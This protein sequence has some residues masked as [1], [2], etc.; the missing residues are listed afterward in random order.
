[1]ILALYVMFNGLDYNRKSWLYKIKTRSSQLI[2]VLIFLLKYS[3]T[4]SICTWFL[5]NQFR[6]WFLL[7][8]QAVKIQFVELDFPSWFLKNQVQMDR[9]SVSWQNSNRRSLVTG[10]ISSEIW[11]E[12]QANI[13]KEPLVC[14]TETNDTSEK[15]P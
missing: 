5:K 3:I 8:T 1:M 10:W 2:V 15:S 14:T 6:N 11:K 9:A 13:L 7:A 12:V 4:L